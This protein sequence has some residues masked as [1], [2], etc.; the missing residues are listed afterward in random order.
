MKLVDKRKLGTYLGITIGT[1]SDTIELREALA[2]C[3]RR[4]LGE[5]RG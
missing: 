1:I 3:D 5:R 2:L 4:E